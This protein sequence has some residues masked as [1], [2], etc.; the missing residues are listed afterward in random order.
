MSTDF[1]WEAIYQGETHESLR[2]GGVIQA[3]EAE[4]GTW[5]R[6]WLGAAHW[7]QQLSGEKH[8]CITR[9]SRKV[10]EIEEI[11]KAYERSR[12]K[13]ALIQS[14]RISMKV[15]VVYLEQQI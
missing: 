1:C 8:F 13:Q 7:S 6:W 14:I 9:R 3:M 15:S 10:G 12:D 5:G 2:A 11:E 4:G